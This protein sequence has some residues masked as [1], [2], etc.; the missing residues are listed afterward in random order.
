ML[1]PLTLSV[2]LAVALCAGGVS[3]AGHKSACSTCGLASPQSAIASPQGV[4]PSAQGCAPAS[5]CG[6]C[7]KKPSFFSNLG[8]LCQP[9]PKT[10][11]YEWVLKKKKVWG[12]KSSGCNVCGGAV[13]PSGQYAATPTGQYSSPQTYSSPVYGASQTASAAVP[14]VGEITPAGEEVPPPPAN[15]PEKPPVP[16]PATPGTASTGMLFSTPSGE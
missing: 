14:P 2:G 16:T 8:K 6:I 3:L 12:H 4:T 5:S 10:Y 1:K 15:V 11:T 13:T 7:G 9:K